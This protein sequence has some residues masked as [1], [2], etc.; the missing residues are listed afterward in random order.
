MAFQLA[1]LDLKVK[2]DNYRLAGVHVDTNHLF[3]AYELQPSPIF[4]GDV[5]QQAFSAKKLI[6]TPLFSALTGLGRTKT[7]EEI[8]Q[9][10]VE[11]NGDMYTWFLTANSDREMRVVENLE[12][13]N[14]AAGQG[15][16]NGEKSTFKIK[17]D[18]RLAVPSEVVSPG[19]HEYQ[20]LV[21]RY[22]GGT[23]STGHIYE[24]QLLSQNY[25]P[26]KFLSV[27]QSWVK[28]GPGIEGERATQGGGIIFDT[29]YKFQNSIGHYRQLFGLTRDAAL[30]DIRTSNM[31][32]GQSLDGKI[33]VPKDDAVMS[34]SF[35]TS[36]YLDN[37]PSWGTPAKGIMSFW[38][39]KGEHKFWQTWFNNLE[40][41]FWYGEK[42]TNTLLNEAGYK[43]KS[44][45]GVKALL[46]HGN[47]YKTT[48]FNA[49]IYEEF[50]EHLTFDRISIDGERSFVAYSG[51]KAIKTFHESLLAKLGQNN[52]LVINENMPITPISSNFHKNAFAY[53]FQ[54]TQYNMPNNISLKLVHNPIYDSRAI[55]KL[56]HPTAPAPIESWTMTFLNLD[57]EADKQNIA[58]VSHGDRYITFV[59]GAGGWFGTT[60][61]IGT[62]TAEY[63]ELVTGAKYG[64]WIRDIT[65]CGEISY[66]YTW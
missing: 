15:L 61:G 50:L 64:I 47:Q 7:F 53:G 55:N 40:E 62:T 30:A 42:T 41:V 43:R 52:V 38:M 63:S 25:I 12:L 20:S 14:P 49:D 28:I 51:T 3:R 34:I 21:K 13:N 35:N 19:V 44:G 54:F 32:A 31:F 10:K 57:T 4:L 16:V 46:R 66:N 65:A 8:K 39:Q 45:G 6:N 26:Q 59:P 27:G 36:K 9:Q 56:E 1:N 24:L 18:K 60:S 2:E 11:I 33:V 23:D 5:I 17:F 48:Y 22:L 37:S 58:L 29:R